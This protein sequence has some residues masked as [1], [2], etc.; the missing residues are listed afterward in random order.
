MTEEDKKLL[1]RF[2]EQQD[3]F[4]LAVYQI[5]WDLLPTG[6]ARL[7]K[8]STAMAEQDRLLFKLTTI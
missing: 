1:L 4:N 2:L 6:D 7:T 8:L 5:V 3:Q